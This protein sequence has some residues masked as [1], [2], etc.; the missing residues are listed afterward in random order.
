[1]SAAKK[2]RISA[3]VTSNVFDTLSNAAELSG[4]TVNQFL[5]AAALKEAERVIEKERVIR[6][7]AENSREFLDALSN[8][9]EPTAKL[10]QFFKEYA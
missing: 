3:R 9:P 5:V 4:S 6:L 2:E 10:V 8:T 1:M 7:N